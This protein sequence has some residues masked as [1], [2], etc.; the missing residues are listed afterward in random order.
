MKTLQDHTLVYDQDCPLCELYTGAFVKT[1]M[2][3]SNG[4]VAFGCARVPAG[5]SNDRAKDEIALIDYRTGTVTYGVDSLL[6]VIGNSFPGL[7]NFLGAR[8]FR[9]PLQILYK[10]ISYNRKVIAPPKEFET[11]GSC[12]PTYHFGYRVAYLILTWLF[13]S[14][15]LT[16]YASLI[17]WLPPTSFG[18]EFYICGGQLLFQLVALFLINSNR[19]MHYLGNMMTVSF[20]GSLLLIPMLVLGQT[21]SVMPEWLVLLWFGTVVMYMFLI[22][23]QR[24]KKLGLS[25]KLSVSWVVYRMMVLWIV[26]G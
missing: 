10:F 23:T 19:K 21:V 6:K 1:G 13:T 26:L 11:R 18:R 15:I 8:V 12:T 5:F 2:L 4:R 24:V 9:L 25:P 14:W 17:T 7:A 16:K 22:H 20:I 3:D